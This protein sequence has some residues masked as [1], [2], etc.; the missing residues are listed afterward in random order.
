MN[1]QNKSID[2]ILN[3][4]NFSKKTLNGNVQLLYYLKICKSATGGKK[5]QMGWVKLTYLTYM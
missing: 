1:L 3:R 2:Q 5:K 4:I